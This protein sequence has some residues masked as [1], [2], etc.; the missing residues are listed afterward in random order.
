[1]KTEPNRLII[2]QL[3]DGDYSSTKAKQK[4]NKLKQELEKLT[5]HGVD[6]VL[7]PHDVN[8]IFDSEDS[9]FTPNKIYE[10]S[11]FDNKKNNIVM[12]FTNNID[13]VRN[14]EGKVYLIIDENNYRG[15]SFNERCMLYF[16]LLSDEQKKNCYMSIYPLLSSLK[17]THITI[18]DDDNFFSN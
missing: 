18:I 9:N 5:K 12:C 14:Y 6:F 8:V 17:N 7:L 4:V 16:G 15:Y 2:L 10:S 11:E 1:M 13:Y 3:P